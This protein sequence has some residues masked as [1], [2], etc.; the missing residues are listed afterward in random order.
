MSLST[1][2]H[3]IGDYSI[4]TPVYQGPLD[5]LLQLIEKAELDITTLA[6]AQITDQ[7]LSHLRQIQDCPADEVSAFLV[8]ATKLIQI[9]SEALLPR[10]PTRQPG[11]DDPGDALAR[12]LI[13]YKRYRQIAEFLSERESADLRSYLRLAQPI[14]VDG[15]V[16]LSDV[17]L[18]DLVTAAQQIFSQANLKIH[19]SNMVPPPRVTIREKIA[20]LA[21]ALRHHKQISFQSLL[22]SHQN[23]LEIVV[24][25]L[26]MLELI[27]RHLVQASQDNLF[28]EIKIDATENWNE[29]DEFELEFGE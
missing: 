23:R 19:L 15:V 12:Q 3:Q 27:K 5:L 20:L 13:A 17:T 16:D 25:F 24:T 29:S 11:E 2:T 9:K 18:L 14:K 22:T 6:L 26:A 28:G 1:A 21:T 4:T 8:I 10:P 7:Y